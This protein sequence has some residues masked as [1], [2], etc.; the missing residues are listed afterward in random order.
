MTFSTLQSRSRAAGI[1]LLALLCGCARPATLL[2]PFRR[3]PLPTVESLIAPMRK[4]SNPVAS[5]QFKARVTVWRSGRPGRQNFEALVGIRPPAT[6]RLRAYRNANQVFDL[7]ADGEGL[8]L[9]DALGK[10]YYRADYASLQRADSL[11]AGVSSKRLIEALLVGP[12]VVSR[13]SATDSTIVRRHWKT[14]EICLETSE[15]RTRVFFNR[16]TRQVVELIEEPKSGGS[17]TRV[18][19]GEMAEIED[20]LLP[21]WVQ[22]SHGPSRTVMRLEIS[23][24]AVDKVLGPRV[25]SLDLPAGQRWQPLEALR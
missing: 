8:R 20:L 5:L 3:E 1:V 22:I 9:H 16:A 2:S 17:P 10:A 21:R 23:D 15:S 24:Y 25:F 19:Y 14:V 18:D 11:W 7:L 13:A 6:A 12:T 4:R